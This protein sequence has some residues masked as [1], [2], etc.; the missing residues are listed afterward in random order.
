MKE[1][2]KEEGD[3][4]FNRYPSSIPLNAQVL[5]AGVPQPPGRLLAPAL[6]S[7][8]GRGAVTE[9]HEEEEL[10]INAALLLKVPSLI[11][12]GDLPCSFGGLGLGIV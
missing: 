10:V 7:H 3:G 11:V 8:E 12:K 1:G 9:T 4:G 5:T 6:G 2:V